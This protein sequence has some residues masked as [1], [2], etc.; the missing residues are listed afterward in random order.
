MVNQ[1]VT[2]TDGCYSMSVQE[3]V[4]FPLPNVSF[5]GQNVCENN[6]VSFVNNSTISSGNIV[7]YVWELGNGNLSNGVSPTELYVSS[8]IYNVSLTATSDN[9]CAAMATQNI[10]IYPNPN[11][12]FMVNNACV[13]NEANFVDISNVQNS[14][15]GNS[16]SSWNWDFG[17]TP[18]ATSNS[19]F[20]SHFYADAGTYPVTLIVT[21]N[22]NCTDTIQQNVEIYPF[23]IVD[24]TVSDNMGCS[25]HCVEFTNLSTIPSGSI[26]QIFWDLGNGNASLDINPQN[27]YN[28]NSL[29]NQNYSIS[30]SVTSDQGC[31]SSLTMPDFVI[32]NP[33][34]IANFEPSTYITSIYETQINFENL[35]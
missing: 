31:V 16:I 35:S 23:P 1:H 33:T 7:D 10:E 11:A 30:L 28:N 18:I 5:T 34:P 8:G 19:Q 25:P 6:E 9:N 22:N 26:S 24:F 21:T 29:V 17:V 27:C 14:G 12:Q 3:I 2:T 4:V 20:A 32:V 13:G 15:S